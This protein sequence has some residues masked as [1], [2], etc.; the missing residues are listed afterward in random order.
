[1]PKNINPKPLQIMKNFSS[2]TVNQRL[3]L[4]HNFSALRPLLL[5]LALTCSSCFEIRE[6]VFIQTDGS[7]HFQL[8]ADFSEQKEMFKELLTKAESNPLNT[9][10]LGAG[11]DPVANIIETWQKGAQQLNEINGISNAEAIINKEEFILGWEFDFTDVNALNLVLALRDGDEYNPNYIPAYRFDK[12]VLYKSNVFSFNKLL[13]QLSPYK[14]GKNISIA[15]KNEKKAIFAG[16][17]Y[18][19]EVQVLGKIKKYSNKAFQRS[20]DKKRLFYKTTLSDIESGEANI[21]N[22][23]KFK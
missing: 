23:I 2:Q 21:S 10:P 7:G 4:W 20:S 13:E 22:K 12:R 18:C 6:V 5:L 3:G 9:G 1:M 19:C 8:L 15:F 16:V 11:E 14:E 17:R